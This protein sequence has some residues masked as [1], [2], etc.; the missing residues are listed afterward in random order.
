[1]VVKCHLYSNQRKQCLKFVYELTV[2]Y[3]AT[4]L[5]YSIQCLPYFS[6]TFCKLSI[7]IVFIKAK[8][9]S[10]CGGVFNQN[11][12]KIIS[13]NYPK[14]YPNSQKCNYTIVAPGKN[15]KLI[16]KSFDLEGEVSTTISINTY[17]TKYRL[18]F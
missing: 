13:P 11:Y 17:I 12:G 6:T 16:F 18:F 2:T 9:T 4:D 5:K 1:M 8:W 10:Y 7:N 14:P 3:K 15:I